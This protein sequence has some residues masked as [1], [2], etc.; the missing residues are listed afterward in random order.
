LENPSKIVRARGVDVA[1]MLG[2][3]GA[4]FEI[5]A[6]LGVGAHGAVYR[7]FDRKRGARVA[8]KVPHEH[9]A[10]ALL[11][12]KDEFRALASIDHPNVVS[13]YELFV[14]DEAWF[15]TMQFVRGVDVLT[16][17]A[18]AP[19]SMRGV[20]LGLLK[21]L[22]TL[23]AN[24]IIHRDIKPSNAWVDAAGT[25]ILLDFGLAS[26]AASQEL[27]R[28]HHA[29]AGTPPYFAPELLDG[30]APSAS[31]DVYALGVLGLEMLT[32]ERLLSSLPRGTRD[33]D[34]ALAKWVEAMLDPDPVRRPTAAEVRIGLDQSPTSIFASTH[35]VAL[36]DRD[37]LAERLKEA[38]AEASLGTP[39]VRILHGP[40]GIGKSTILERAL[41]AA[42]AHDPHLVVL[43]GRC[44]EHETVPFA[45]IDAIVDQLARKL[46]AAEDNLH[47]SLDPKEIARL[48]EAFPVFSGVRQSL[49]AT[50]AVM[51]AISDPQERLRLVAEAL[52]SVLTKLAE[53]HPLALV[54]DDAQWAEEDGT[55]LLVEAMRGLSHAPITLLVSHRDAQGEASPSLA[56]LLSLHGNLNVAHLAVP[57]LSEADAEALAV[58]LG[59]TPS[60]RARLLR[61]SAG[62]PFLME[63]LALGGL[64]VPERLE[65]E[66]DANQLARAAI[67]RRLHAL[68]PSALSLFETVCV[69]GHPVPLEVAVRASGLFG[70][71][72][73][74]R[75]LAMARLIRSNP[76]AADRDHRIAESDPRRA[77]LEVYHDRL[78]ELTLASLPLGRKS[79]IHATLATALEAAEGINPMWI[80]IHLEGAGE[81]ERAAAYAESGAHRALQKLAFT[82]AAELFRFA[83]QHR[84]RSELHQEAPRLHMRSLC[85]ALAESLANAGRGHEA[86]QAYL[87]ACA[88]AT[89]A[90]ALLDLRRRAAEQALRS[91]FIAEGTKLLNEV[92]REAG[93]PLRETPSRA[94]LGLLR[95]RIWIHRHGLHAQQ[96]WMPDAAEERRID[97]CFSGATGLSVV[98][99]IRSADLMTEALRRSLSIGDPRR[100]AAALGWYTAFLANGGGPAEA[101]TRAVLA[102]ARAAVERDGDA[103]ARGCFEAAS[104]LVEFHLGHLTH[105]EAAC[106]RAE[107][108]FA[109]ETIGTTKEQTTVNTFQLASLALLGRLRE[110]SERTETL[111]RISEARGERY[112]LTNYRQGLMVLRHLTADAPER[113]VEDLDA[114]LGEFGGEGFLV[115]HFF[116][117]WGRITTALYE[118]RCTDARARYLRTRGRVLRSLLIRTQWTRGHTFVLE[119]ATAIGVF[120]TQPSRRAAM[121]IELVLRQLER[122][123]RTWTS[124]LAHALHACLQ[125]A[126]GDVPRAIRPLEQAIPELEQAELG[127]Y[128]DAAR[129]LLAEVR[130]SEQDTQQRAAWAA[131]ER[132]VNPSA[133]ARALLPGF[134]PGCA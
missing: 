11:R 63:A 70:D 56:K 54:I 120:R 87:E 35:L 90:E 6:R 125:A 37:A 48:E 113:A 79:S 50:S 20:L 4:R 74:V 26:R 42:S 33:V 101:S 77:E 105:A 8:L 16:H 108:V 66:G 78:R 72:A 49:D 126:R 15:F 75:T 115:Q 46:S 86:A 98:D 59:A 134:T 28:V 99:S 60:Q 107:A 131:R 76:F 40:A 47:A 9:D 64:E 14:H 68:P 44:S 124:A 30:H 17:T 132:I 39:T 112:A 114:A 45:T 36:P 100:R 103:Y 102:E 97:A 31:S 111:V 130:G 82:R 52:S 55:R 119:A 23:H 58:A 127:L 34:P 109:L 110:L 1:R 95:N 93:A 38:I 67:T 118:G 81:L 129:A 21:G 73:S 29:H 96:R 32:G 22:E 128:A 123:N 116:D 94:I 61:E 92:L 65:P 62:S 19:E 10:H 25:P 89:D 51:S 69:A 3:F 84:N 80:C 53:R 104:S 83:I 122:E 57:P 24:G 41:A 91:G 12:V 27:E 71:L 133:F 117:L 18:R 7:A 13:F 2:D 121:W 5:E 106:R 43:R 85:V 88:Y